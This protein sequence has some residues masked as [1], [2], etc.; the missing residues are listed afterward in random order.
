MRARYLKSFTY[1]INNLYQVETIK[2]HGHTLYI[3]ERV[4]T[5]MPSKS[6][7]KEGIGQVRW[8]AEKGI[9]LKSQTVN[10]FCLLTEWIKHMSSDCM[11]FLSLKTYLALSKTKHI[12]ITTVIRFITGY[13]IYKTMLCCSSPQNVQ[14]IDEFSMDCKNI[15]DSQ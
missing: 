14:D 2:T 15:L 3:R 4:N 12:Q 11:L 13:I 1:L 7:K 9:L 10:N 5:Y 8:I 6:W